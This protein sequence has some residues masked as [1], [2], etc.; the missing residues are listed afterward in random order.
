MKFEPVV[1]DM[2]QCIQGM[3]FKSLSN[4]LSDSVGYGLNFE[5]N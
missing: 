3:K 5:R 4:Q 1:G 2:K